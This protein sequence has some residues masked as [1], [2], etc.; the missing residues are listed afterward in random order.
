M[1]R[2]REIN[3]ACVSLKTEGVGLPGHLVL[4]RM[5]R[6]AR[7]EFLILALQEIEDRI[8][9]DG[10]TIDFKVKDIA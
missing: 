6:E 8:A 5:T 2:T 7:I 10:K 9:R 3:T 4:G 1:R